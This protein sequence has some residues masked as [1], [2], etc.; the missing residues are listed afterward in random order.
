VNYF[1]K[2]NSGW[3]NKIHGVTVPTNMNYHTQDFAH[4]IGRGCLEKYDFAF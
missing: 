3:P 2:L 1:W 4:L